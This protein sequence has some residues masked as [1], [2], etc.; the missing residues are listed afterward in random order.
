MSNIINKT[1]LSRYSPL[2]INYDYSE[3]MN[4]V[5]VAQEIWIRPLIGYDLFEEIEQ[6]VKDNN[7]SEEN[8][9]LMTEGFLLQYL[10]YATCLEGLPFIWSHFSQTGISLGKSDNSDSITLKDLTYIQQHLRN[11]VEVLKDSVKRYICS[12]ALYYPK[13]DLCSCNCD[14][15]C[16]HTP[17]LNAPNPQF[18]VYKPYKMNTNLR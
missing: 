9:A 16:K 3:I 2:P 1:L 5:P 17:Q 14:G 6:Q 11:Q 12:H 15:C 8:Q 13:A 18:Q 7:L 4:Y 10:S